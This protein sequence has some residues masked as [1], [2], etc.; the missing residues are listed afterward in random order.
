MISIFNFV[1]LLGVSV[2]ELVERLY[3]NNMFTGPT[4]IHVYGVIKALLE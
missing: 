2:Y 4:F 3:G 1:I